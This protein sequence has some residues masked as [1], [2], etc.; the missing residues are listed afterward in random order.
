VC[1]SISDTNDNTL[2]RE[3][4]NFPIKW[5][6]NPDSEEG[7]TNRNIAAE[8]LTTD[9]ITFMDCDDLVHSQRNEFILKAFHEGAETFVH[10]YVLGSRDLKTD[11]EKNKIFLESVHNKPVILKDY[12]TTFGTPI[13]PQNEVNRNVHYHNAHVSVTKEIFEKIKYEVHPFCDSYYT[14]RLVEN[15]YKIWYTPNELSYYI[16]VK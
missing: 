12:L 16:L 11:I 1:V 15:G 7:C 2:L 10:S 9:I 14:R 13:G 8:N 6:R 3:N 4:F 5:I